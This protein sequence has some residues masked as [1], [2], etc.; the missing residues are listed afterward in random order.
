MLS[1]NLNFIL[2]KGLSFQWHTD[3]GQVTIQT[4]TQMI[5]RVQDYVEFK[6]A[7]ITKAFSNLVWLT[8]ILKH[9]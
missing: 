9:S 2:I 4:L 8:Q 7:Q 1:N 5:N 3:Q 6:Q